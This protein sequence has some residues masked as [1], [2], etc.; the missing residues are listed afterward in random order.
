MSN[1]SIYEKNWIDLVFEGK[2][3]AYGAYQLRQE[4]SK[5]SLI[6]FLSGIT[7]FCGAIGLG[8]FLTS[9]GDIPTPSPID[10]DIV[11][12]VDNFTYP[13]K[14]NEEPKKDVVA[15]LIEDEPTQKIES[16][17]LVD[18]IIVKSNDNPDDITKN[19]DLSKNNDDPNPNGGDTK[20][21]VI[22]TTTGG[23]STGTSTDGDGES[24]GNG[25]NTTNELDKLPLYPGGMK[26][27]Y[28][29]VVN[30][31][32]RPEIEEDGEVTLS[33]I[34]SF[35][36]EKDGSL[37]DI[38]AVRSTD[39]KLEKEAIRLLKASKVKWSPG[40]KDGKPVRTLFMLPIKVK[41]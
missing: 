37:T 3:K 9:F 8:L 26:R 11:I 28:E 20:G 17:D 12:R 39:Y 33:V 24:K 40:I 15:P 30:N 34:M 1:V 23:T 41:L 32:N 19:V 27:F 14:K 36:I 4:N 10:E 21:T 16:K 25:I 31:F 2:N 38:K 18:P 6:A 22:S 5:T 35:V 29:Y 7:F 13:P